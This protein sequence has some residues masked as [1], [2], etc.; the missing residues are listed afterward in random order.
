MRKSKIQKIHCL[1]RQYF[2]IFDNNNAVH[3]KYELT[4]YSLNNELYV[5]LYI[6][7]LH[8]AQVS[9]PSKPFR[10]D[11]IKSYYRKKN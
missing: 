1:I 10:P 7:F 8:F 2:I 11:F 9:C 3:Y 5:S 6:V 4:I